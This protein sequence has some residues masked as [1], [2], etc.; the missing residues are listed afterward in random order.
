MSK[1]QE[2]K[3]KIGLKRST[4]FETIINQVAPKIERELGKFAQ[5]LGQQ[6]CLILHQ[7]ESLLRYELYWGCDINPDSKLAFAGNLVQIDVS[8][9]SE[10]K[11]A[12]ISFDAGLPAYFEI[13]Q[14]RFSTT[15]QCLEQDL[16]SFFLK[17]K[18]SQINTYWRDDSITA[19]S[20]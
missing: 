8:L 11:A 15:A 5:Y 3:C 6:V 4:E 1:E 2:E 9:E 19:A 12:V 7:S 13:N 14:H 16:A 18:T 17:I 20:F 10:E